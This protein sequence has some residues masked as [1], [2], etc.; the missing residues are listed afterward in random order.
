MT[1][2]RLGVYV[3]GIMLGVFVL[4]ILIDQLFLPAIVGSA[5]TIVVP[6]VRGMNEDSARVLLT[7]LGLA[8]EEPHE[9]F[10]KDIPEG[11]V[12]SQMPYVGATVKEGRRIY[13]TVSSG[14][15]SSL[16]PR[17]TGM[18]LREARLA[19]VRL[20]LQVGDVTFEYNDSIP[21][22]RIVSQSI[23]SGSKVK[24][25]SVAHLVISQ[26]PSSQHMPDLIGL[27]MPEATAILQD[28]Q[29]TVGN[30]TY[31][32]TG[33]FLPNTVIGHEPPADSLI[34]PGGVVTL[35]VTK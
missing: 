32:E 4:A 23:R 12:I 25:G 7:S 1:W 6:D 8:V 28:Y 2:K 14:V 20:G 17:L 29:L 27:S 30:I 22:D 16:M 33:T 21:E 34:A 26:G 15:E 10:N 31:I 19:L 5:E 11:S 3:G 13:L 24:T 9:Q 18:S 35:T